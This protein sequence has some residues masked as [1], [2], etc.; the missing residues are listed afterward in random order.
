MS[1]HV[2]RHPFSSAYEQEELFSNLK[3]G[4]GIMES[5]VLL[6]PLI[7]GMTFA[8]AFCIW[9]IRKEVRSDLAVHEALRSQFGGSHFF[10]SV[11]GIVVA[12]I[13][14]VLMVGFSSLLPAQDFE[15]WVGDAMYMVIAASLVMILA[16]T[17]MSVQSV[18]SKINWAIEMDNLPRFQGVFIENLPL[19]DQSG[20]NRKYRSTIRDQ[21]G[22]VCSFICQVSALK[23]PWFPH[24]Q[25]VVVFYRTRES[26]AEI[27]YMAPV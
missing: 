25:E 7:F 11:F 13:M 10:L 2:R 17:I 21:Q 3:R 20:K 27:A 22:R 12:G 4:E 15:G 23:D 1:L 19:D 16:I 9:I 14:A 8:S 26:V 6:Y 24:R 18:V 5:F